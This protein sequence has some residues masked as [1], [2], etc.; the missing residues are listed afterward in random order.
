[1]PEPRVSTTEILRQLR[2]LSAE[3]EDI[4]DDGTPITKAEKLARLLWKK[5]LGSKEMRQTEKGMVEVDCPPESWAILTIMDRL[6]GKVANAVEDASAKTTAAD[7][8]SA[9]ARDRINN[10]VGKKATPPK[11]LPPKIKPL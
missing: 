4:A 11:P 1:M 2:L 5:A 9:L 10:M 8:V 6:M 3:A 7:K